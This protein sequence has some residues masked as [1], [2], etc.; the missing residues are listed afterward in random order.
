MTYN[1]Y[2]NRE[3]IIVHTVK[4]LSPPHVKQAQNSGLQLLQE[5]GCGLKN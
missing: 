4:Y 5:T 3:N 2:D 1:F